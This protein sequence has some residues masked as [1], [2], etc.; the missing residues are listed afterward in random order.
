MNNSAPLSSADDSTGTRVFAG[1]RVMPDTAHAFGG[2]WRL[3]V[4]RFYS[5]TRWLIFAGMLAL[6]ALF[7][8]AGAPTRGGAAREFLPW[9]SRFYVCFLVPVFA[10]LGAAGVVRDDLQ[11]GSVDYLF[12]RP[13][14]RPVFVVLRYLAHTMCAQ[15]DFLLPLGM[16]VAIG[17]VRGVPGIW[18]AVPMLLLAQVLMTVAFSAFGFLAAMLTSRYVV[19]GLVYGA[20]IEVGLGNVPTQLNRLSMI[21]Q[22]LNILHPLLGSQPPARP[23]AR[24]IVL[25]V[26]SAPTAATLLLGTSLAMVGLAALIFAL[27]EPAGAAGREP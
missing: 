26:L 16:L 24:T 19:I 7:S 1:P 17:S 4:R 8:F 18:S 27:R 5:P 9:V 20:V 10:F 15:I 25:E 3:S 6:L 23:G 12:T 22:A 2:I 21:R 11:P 14:R 13:I